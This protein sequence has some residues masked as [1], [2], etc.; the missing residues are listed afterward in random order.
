MVFWRKNKLVI[1]LA[2]GLEP[3]KYVMVQEA[4]P[5]K[6]YSDA[7]TALSQVSIVLRK[8]SAGPIG[9]IEFPV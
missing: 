6:K 8:N 4:N 2:Y 1:I 5:V 7:L 3:E 9:I